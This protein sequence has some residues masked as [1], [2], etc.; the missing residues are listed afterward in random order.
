MLICGTAVTSR[1]SRL[2][3]HPRHVLVLCL[4]LYL[5]PCLVRSMMLCVLLCLV[6][7]LVLFLDLCLLCLVLCLVLCLDLCLQRMFAFLQASAREAYDPKEFAKVFRS[8]LGPRVS[9]CRS[10][11][12]SARHLVLQVR[13]AA[14]SVR[15]SEGRVRVLLVPV[16]AG[17]A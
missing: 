9:S 6:L 3:P 5:E 10:A 12:F 2:T 15:C 11:A 8:V 13:R 7:C 14:G 17:R 1:A 4:V 16:A